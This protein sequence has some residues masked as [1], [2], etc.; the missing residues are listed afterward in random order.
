MKP[1]TQRELQRW[2]DDR[3]R[4]MDSVTLQAGQPAAI[5]PTVWIHLKSGHLCEVVG[6]GVD[7]LSLE[8]SVEYW[9]GFT[10]W[11]RDLPEFLVNFE[12]LGALDDE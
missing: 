7:E 2:L 3:A 5:K 9:D 1:E 10:R 12:L 6:V 11:H 4:N 8:R